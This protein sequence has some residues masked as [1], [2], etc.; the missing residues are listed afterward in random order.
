MQKT[1][2]H[3]RVPNPELNPKR[4]NLHILKMEKNGQAFSV[5]NGMPHVFLETNQPD[6]QPAVRG[7]GIPPPQP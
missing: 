1:M 3:E 5:T 4:S 2:S 7:D 6:T